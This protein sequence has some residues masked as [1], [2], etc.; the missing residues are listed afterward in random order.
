MG[1]QHR[2]HRRGSTL[3]FRDGWLQ[4]SAERSHAAQRQPR[5]LIWVGIRH[6]TVQDGSFDE[7]AGGKAR[8]EVTVGTGS[9]LP[10]PN[11][12]PQ[13]GRALCGPV[14]NNTAEEDESFAAQPSWMEFSLS[15][16]TRLR[17]L[18]RLQDKP[19]SEIMRRAVEEC[20]ARSP[21]PSCQSD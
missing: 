21:E 13:N 20:L 8:A 17:R 11:S 5:L 14:V 7:Y 16:M 4:R 1:V 15:I 19:V 9:E 18:A 6:Q 2:T 10:T 12:K 3:S